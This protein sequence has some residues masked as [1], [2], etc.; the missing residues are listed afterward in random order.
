MMSA[1]A[2]LFSFC[3]VLCNITFS[4]SEV[5]LG[6]HIPLSSSNWIVDAYSNV[7]RSSKVKFTVALKL[8][9]GDSLNQEFLDISTPGSPKYGKHLNIHEI[10]SK[11][12]PNTAEKMEV[13]TF[14]ESIPGAKVNGRNLPGDFITIEA[15]I[16][17]VEDMLETKLSWRV[18]RH[19]LSKSRSLRADKAISLPDRVQSLISFISLNTPIAHVTTGD[20]LKREEQMKE[21]VSKDRSYLPIPKRVEKKEVKTK[22]TSKAVGIQTPSDEVF[23]SRGNEEAIISFPLYCN[24]EL[25]DYNP[26]CPDLEISLAVSIYSYS[27]SPLASDYDSSY[28]LDTD[29]TVFTFPKASVYCAN[30]YTAKDCGVNGPTTDATNCTCMAKLAPLPKYTQLQASIAV[31]Y[32]DAQ[33]VAEIVNGGS[34][35]LFALTDV[36]TASFLMDL[37]NIPQGLTVRYGSNQSV[38]EFYEEYYSNSDLL[39][40]LSLSGLRNATI[41][42]SNVVGNND[43]SDPGGEA[44]LDV[45]YIMALAPGAPT[46]FYS[47]SELNPANPEYNNEGF[48]SY[49]TDVNNMADIALV[50]SLSYGDL[51][52]SV[53]D[54]TNSS[55]YEY[56]TRCDQEFQKLGLRGVTVL[57]SSGD[58]GIGDSI[59]RDDVQAGC[60]QAN[61]SWPASSPYV[62]AIGGTQLIDD[63]LPLCQNTY[64]TRYAG[65]PI[66]SQLNAQCSGVKETVCSS[67]LGGV[68]TS[69][70]GFSDVSSRAETAPWQT[71]AVNAYLNLADVT[72]PTSY[73]NPEGRGYPD[74]ATYA[75]NYFVYLNGKITRESGTSASAPVFAAMVTLWNDMR[76]SYGLPPMGFIA[77]F[78]YQIAQTNPETFND[79]T[80]GN[81]ACGAGGSIDTVN[82]CEYS[83][84]AAPGWDAVTG[85]GSPNFGVIANLVLNLNQSFPT[86]SESAVLQYAAASVPTTST[87]TNN[88]TDDKTAIGIALALGSVALVM[89]FASL[90]FIGY[91]YYQS[92]QQSHYGLLDARDGNNVEKHLI[93]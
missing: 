86:V 35:H 88:Y 19:Q 55:A 89:S 3:I 33:N 21:L 20:V 9:D 66:T 2:I 38:V 49:L 8:K 68:I 85:L 37:Y 82:C 43:E 74:V 27:N 26:P 84:S 73:F 69:G 71:A 53:F 65:L 48:L 6:P 31:T 4:S 15:P 5:Y 70:G 76:L 7:D 34:S 91:L 44:Q 46:Y 39:E 61:P 22:R 42:V 17:A 78:L 90:C 12:G 16:S 80:T 51:E 75:S 56:G 83:F 36:A 60:K 32:T 63:H 13:V 28:L 50:Q 54:T 47:Y 10:Q 67:T 45:E 23:I 92:R 30:S 77:P 64:Y 29:P 81:N 14:F 62:T 25:N 41:P 87:T 79:I 57:F 58:D 11:F 1:L 40:F 93:N 24:G 59:I 72:P 52:S 18:H